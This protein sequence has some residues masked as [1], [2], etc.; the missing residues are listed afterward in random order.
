MPPDDSAAGGVHLLIP[1]S[2]IKMRVHPMRH[3]TST[4]SLELL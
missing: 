2:E 3:D 4:S 1:L